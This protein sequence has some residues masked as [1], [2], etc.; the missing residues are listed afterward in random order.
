MHGNGKHEL[1][2]TSSSPHPHDSHHISMVLTSSAPHL[3]LIPYRACILS[4]F[5]VEEGVCQMIKGSSNFVGFIKPGSFF[6]ED[7]LWFDQK[8]MDQVRQTE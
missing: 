6:S 2:L 8:Q 7:A 1:I 5:F 3:N 4:Q